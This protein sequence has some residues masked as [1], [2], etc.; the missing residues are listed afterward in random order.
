M[1]TFFKQTH[2]THKHTHI[3]TQTHTERK[4]DRTHIL[5]G[6]VGDTF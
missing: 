2:D 3:Q 4:R 6:V 5:N 1:T